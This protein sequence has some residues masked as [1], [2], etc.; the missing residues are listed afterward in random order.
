VDLHP[1]KHGV[2]LSRIAHIV[3][4]SS[5]PKLIIRKKREHPPHAK[6]GDF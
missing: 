1:P 4:I 6:N 2:D 3:F 5:V